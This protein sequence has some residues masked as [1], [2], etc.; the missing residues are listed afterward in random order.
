MSQR[1]PLTQTEEI[2]RALA[3]TAYETGDVRLTRERIAGATHLVA[4]RNGLFAIDPDRY[5][6]VAFGSFYGLTIRDGAMYAFE[7]CD[8]AGLGTERGRIVRLERE[9]DRIASG[10]VLAKELDNGC[11]QID[12]LGDILHV[13]DT[14]NQRVLRFSAEGAPLDT[15]HP[16]PPMAERRWGKGYVHIN[17]L[18]QVGDRTLL[19]LHNG[20]SHTGQRSEVALFDPDWREVARWPLP[21]GGC[22]NLV[23]LEDGTLLSCGSMAGEIIGLDG[24]KVQVSEMMTRGLSI[25]AD[26]IVVGAAKF[27]SRIDRQVSPGTVAFL[28]RDYARRALVE[29]PGAPTEIRS[30]D[31]RDLGI[32]AFRATLPPVL[33]EPA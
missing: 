7:A 28:G 27:T 5:V 21:G 24:P 19:L 14:T 30:L 3:L 1:R 11:H 26:M 29:L 31:G 2:A 17:S 4:T 15:V 18:M 23:V 6:R 9:G 10:A 22:H 25:D 13:L 20:V 33:R 32:S 16:L 12:F 8:L